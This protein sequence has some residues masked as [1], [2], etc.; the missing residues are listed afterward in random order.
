MQIPRF[1]ANFGKV[2]EASVQN[3]WRLPR[4][5]RYFRR[6]PEYVSAGIIPIGY[7]P[8]TNDYVIILGYDYELNELRA[9][10]SKVNPK[11]D[12][13]MKH[14]AARSA[15]E[16]SAGLINI[17]PSELHNKKFSTY[18]VVTQGKLYR[19]ICYFVRVYGLSD[20]RF[21]ES[22]LRNISKASELIRKFSKIVAIPLSSLIGIGDYHSSRF[23]WDVTGQCY[24][25]SYT[26][27][28]YLKD[29]FTPVTIIYYG[30]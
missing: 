13:N 4:R 2:Y 10:A 19:N 23:V 30:M 24:M 12:G 27:H 3:N 5:Q 15:Y 29:M 9:F 1:D 22:Q 16:L 14:V 17:P 11:I 28:R 21:R 8:V 7:D 6:N 20:D 18:N 26:T 25:L